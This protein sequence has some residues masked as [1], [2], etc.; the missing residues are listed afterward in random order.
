MD[1]GYLIV[2]IIGSPLI[3]WFVFYVKKHM[4]NPTMEKKLAGKGYK[5]CGT[6]SSGAGA[7]ASIGI[8]PDDDVFLIRGNKTQPI[9]IIEFSRVSHNAHL[10]ELEISF[11]VTD[12]SCDDRVFS[13]RIKGK[14]D[15]LRTYQ[16]R[17]GWSS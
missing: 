13:G 5:Y 3:I 9:E 4:K 12:G 8:S 2:L 11:T 16:N 7:G 17:L 15:E 14:E 10:L 6:L 1:V